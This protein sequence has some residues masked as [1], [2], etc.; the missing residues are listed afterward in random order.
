[1][2]RPNDHGFPGRQRGTF[3]ILSAF[4]LLL[5]LGFLALV[6]DSGRLFLEKRRLQKLADSAALEAITRLPQG[7]CAAASSQ[8][9]QYASE[10]AG[11]N[12]FSTGAE[13][14]TL[15]VQCVTLQAADGL[16]NAVPAANGRAVRVEVTRRVPSSLVMRT[17]V[18]FSPSS[19]EWITLGA[20][21]VAE[22]SE[23]GASFSVGAQLLR[24]DGDK[25]LGRLLAA[26]GL[27]PRTLSVLDSEGL[28]NVA[29]APAGL[30]HALGVDLGIDQLRALSPQ[31]LVEL[32]DTRIGLLGLDEL[33]D[34][35]LQVVS[36]SVLKAKLALLRQDILRNPI[37]R[38]IRVRLLGT[39]DTPGLLSI[40]S[41][42]DGQV[43]PALDTR[44][45]LGDLLKTSLLLGLPEEQR[46]LKVDEIS[47]L[48]LATVKVGIVEPPSIGVGPVG[49]TAFNAQIRV[50]VNVD[51]DG[52]TLV[53]PLT[54]L[55][56]IRIKLPIILDLVSSTGTLDAVDCQAPKPTASIRMQSQLGN[57]C[58]G[59]IPADA[60]WAT[61]ASCASNVAD[62]NLIRLP[63]LSVPGKIVLPI[64]PANDEDVTLTVGE[65]V[66]TEVNHLPIGTLVAD[67]TRE[68]LELL[69]L[70]ANA[71]SRDKLLADAAADVADSYLA[72]A[73]LQPT[74]AGQYSSA[75]LNR[76]RER[77]EHDGFDW[78][79]PGGLLGLGTQTVMQ[80]WRSNVGNRCS[81]TNKAAACVRGELVKSLQQNSQSGL[82]DGLLGSVLGLLQNLL[83]NTV[84]PLL[85][86]LLTPVVQLL[87]PLLDLV[88]SALSS[89]LAGLGLELGRTDVE[90]HA[91]SC[92][93]PRLV[94]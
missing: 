9:L 80:E 25:L 14:H 30:L 40:E 21:A 72:L 75:D 24:L 88:G 74:A 39:P 85:A 66:S 23:P 56:G 22:R 33:L 68:L 67:L 51:T 70:K 48:G 73:A 36:D 43:G 81:G 18:L 53:G 76:I 49:T 27:D 28:A 34:L 69:K 26:A 8:A 79:R 93:I 7:D 65:T 86:E 29:V 58:V 94:R 1:M 42:P 89:L 46:A 31:G 50:L 54:N 77:L 61:R 52:A 90:L 13:G 57:L 45:K 3:S 16:R 6:L 20:S 4:V 84:Q 78:D 2:R 15:T 55:L 32:V 83:G 63:G 37:L 47:L 87:E 11:R 91:L 44:V 59:R 64:L 19:P 17:S 10:N 82:L 35:S 60:L 12:G 38:D 92:G 62:E 71:S 41:T 5:A